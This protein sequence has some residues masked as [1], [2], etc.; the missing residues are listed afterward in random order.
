MRRVIAELMA[1]GH[2]I[3]LL[4]VLLIVLT[5]VLLFVV[6]VQA[7]R[8]IRKRRNLRRLLESWSKDQER[9]Q[10]QSAPENTRQGALF[11]CCQ[12]S[13]QVGAPGISRCCCWLRS[14]NS[15]GEAG[16]VL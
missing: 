3:V 13:D 8:E 4:A 2:E 15:M 10:S 14:A 11:D 7:I 1:A 16:P 6:T 9:R 12:R 5:A